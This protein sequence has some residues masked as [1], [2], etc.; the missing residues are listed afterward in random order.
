MRLLNTKTYTL[1][2][3]FGKAIPKYA[4]LSHRWEDEEVLFQDLESGRAHSMPGYAKI[5]GC[6][7]QARKDHFEYAWIDT[8]CIDKSSSAELSEAI[9]SMFQWYK[10]SNVCYAYL[11]DVTGRGDRDQVLGEFARSIWFDRGWTLQELLA[12]NNVVFYDQSWGCIGTK[13]NLDGLIAE[14]TGIPGLFSYEKACI[15]EKM[16]WASWRETTRVEDEAYCLMGLFNVNMPLLYGEGAKAFKRLQQEI[17]KSSDDE[18]IFAWYSTDTSGDIFA[19]NPRAFSES[20]NVKSRTFISSSTSTST[21][22]HTFKR[23]PADYRLYFKRD[24]H[25]YA[26]T[27]KGLHI[28]L[29]LIPAQVFWNELH[30]SE[31]KQRLRDLYV[32]FL[33][34]L[35][36]GA[37][38]M[39]SPAIWLERIYEQDENI[40]IDSGAW[41]LV[42][43]PQHRILTLN[44]REIMKKCQ[45]W[46]RILET[47]DDEKADDRFRL[48]SRLVY[49]RTDLAT[50]LPAPK[51]LNYLNDEFDMLINISSLQKHSFELIWPR[52]LDPSIGPQ[53]ENIL[54]FGTVDGNLQVKVKYPLKPD[55]EPFIDLY[56]TNRKSGQTI[57]FTVNVRDS[58]NPWPMLLTVD[59]VQSAGEAQDDVFFHVSNWF[60][61][62]DP[63][64]SGVNRISHALNV[65][66]SVSAFVRRAIDSVGY[67][68]KIDL[69]IERR[70]SIRW[71]ATNGLETLAAEWLDE[72]DSTNKA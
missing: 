62:Q 20:W 23:G 58:G 54:C 21:H 15:A 71:P 19:P 22:M 61:S 31:D 68:Y 11:S 34:G 25:P 24:E 32:T 60:R 44:I 18:S 66:W 41:K 10:D 2:T 39:V 5:R 65:G 56:F 14:I 27:N 13:G 7:R 6:C 29:F 38:D 36:M 17:I 63:D 8:C 52:F 67:R 16:S 72:Y 48:T 45:E 12:P 33:H 1:H 26:M 43:V 37:N 40:S 3:F 47:K 55:P 64:L 53:R 49:I 35:W 50:P 30:W 42:R 57:V 28:S 9:N 4:I 46:T 70:D 69:T 59:D 51:F